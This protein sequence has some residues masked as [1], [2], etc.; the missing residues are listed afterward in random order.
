[1]HTLKLFIDTHDRVNGTFPVGLTPTQFE[2]FFSDYERACAEEGVIPMGTHVG[3][4][5]GRAYC[6]NLAP[7]AEAIRRAHER[8]GL[9]FDSVTEVS[10]ASPH[11]TFFR[12][13]SL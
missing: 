11:S 5:D 2:S 7:D 13:Q 8:V 9:P 10:T 1:M 12:R 4:E 6:L 3:Y